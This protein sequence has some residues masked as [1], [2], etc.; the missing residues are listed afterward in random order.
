MRT[1]SLHRTRT[2]ILLVAFHSVVYASPA[3]FFSDGFESG[4][5]LTTDSPP[6]AW[7]GE[8][9]Q[10]GAEIEVISS[11]TYSGAYALHIATDGLHDITPQVWKNLGTQYAI[12]FARC[13]LRFGVIN[14]GNGSQ[15]ITWIIGNQASPYKT[16][17]A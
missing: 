17:Q 7:D 5:I 4:I 1:C 16:T 12:T 15:L 11:T 3:V 13:Y 14:I 6:S 8:Q 9:L 2:S 10:I